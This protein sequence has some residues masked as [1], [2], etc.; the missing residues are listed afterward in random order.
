MPHL[1]AQR[2]TDRGL[3]KREVWERVWEL[4]RAEDRGEDV[5]TIPV[6]PKY[7]QA[8]FRSG[9]LL[10]AS[11][12]ARRP[13]GALRADPERRARRGRVAGR[14]LGRLERARPRAGARR[15]G[16]GAARAA[17][18]RRRALVPL[19]AGVLEL[20]PWIHQWHPESDPLFGGPPGTFFEGWLDGELAALGDH[21]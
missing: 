10:E 18:R 17:R 9:D 7:A 1:A 16:H 19:L 4:Q 14:R 13:E 12:Q 6:P 3:R 15:P 20:L 5:G 11:R 21:A 2:L 8:D